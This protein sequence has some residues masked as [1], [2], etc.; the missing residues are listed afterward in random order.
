MKRNILLLI[1]LS[2]TMVLLT[3]CGGEDYKNFDS[4]TYEEIGLQAKVPQDWTFGY[5]RVDNLTYNFSF[6]DEVGIFYI[7][8]FPK[9][10]YS[11][12]YIN[13]EQTEY[14]RAFLIQEQKK[15]SSKK[16][17]LYFTARPDGWFN[18]APP[19]TKEIC[20]VL[21]ELGDRILEITWDM[22]QG[23]YETHQDEIRL[24]HESVKQAK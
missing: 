21:M 7:L 16:E 1:V 8:A 19:P 10:S 24:V 12:K 6:N 17:L 9:D 14:K 23:Y 18:N 22:P 5:D 20:V 13:D 11:S 3:S 15:L 4:R 2:L